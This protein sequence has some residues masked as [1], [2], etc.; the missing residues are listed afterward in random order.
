MLKVESKQKAQSFRNSGRKHLVSYKHK[1]TKET[2]NFS[3]IGFISII[4]KNNLCTKL[5]CYNQTVDF[6]KNNLLSLLKVDIPV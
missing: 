1:E 4:T 6:F 3:D 5:A 2:K